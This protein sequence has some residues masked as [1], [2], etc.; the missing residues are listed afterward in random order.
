MNKKSFWICLIILGLIQF[1]GCQQMK[2]HP[3]DKEGFSLMDFLSVVPNDGQVVGDTIKNITIEFKQSVNPSILQSSLFIISEQGY[4]EKDCPLGG[5][6]T[7]NKLVTWLNHSE[8][9]EHIMQHHLVNG[10]FDWEL[11]NSRCLYFFSSSLKA[12][13]NYFIIISEKAANEFKR[14]MTSSGMLPSGYCP[15]CVLSGSNAISLIYSFKT[16]PIER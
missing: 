8:A 15:C 16:F 14:M 9:R 12:H 13:N 4:D 7:K 1:I 5:S 3:T 10:Y 2:H 11:D 6:F